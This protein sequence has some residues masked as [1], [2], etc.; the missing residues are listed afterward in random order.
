MV[1]SKLRNWLQYQWL[2][3]NHPKYHHL[4]DEWVSNIT[5]SQILGFTKQMF[6]L[7]NSILG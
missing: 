1:T 4:F 7:E 2:K 5:E 6:N 3:C